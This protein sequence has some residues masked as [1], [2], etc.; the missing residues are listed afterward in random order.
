MR[1]E[2]PHLSVSMDIAGCRDYMGSLCRTV[3]DCRRQ[4][5]A[6]LCPVC[7]TN[8]CANTHTLTHT[9]REVALHGRRQGEHTHTR[10][11]THTHTQTHAR[12]HEKTPLRA[13]MRYKCSRVQRHT[14]VHVHTLS[15]THTL[16]GTHTCTHT[17][18]QTYTHA[19][20]RTH[21]HTH[22][23]THTAPRRCTLAHH[24]QNWHLTAPSSGRK[25][26]GL[27]TACFLNLFIECV[28]HLA[29]PTPNSPVLTSG[30]FA[31]LVM[32]R[33]PR[34]LRFSHRSMTPR[35]NFYVT[36]GTDWTIFSTLS[37]G[38][39]VK[40]DTLASKSLTPASKSLTP[41]CLCENPY[42]FNTLHWVS[43]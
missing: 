27:E 7:I 41:P 21:T 16:K 6:K 15:A 24:T 30:L 13:H 36:P 23:H 10:T 20:T 34:E 14:R 17:N 33:A 25:N 40:F 19:H 2:S 39:H 43:C 22:T 3:A 35:Q 9:H 26:G 4:Y 32:R 28:T 8:G 38:H 11:H 5:D 42:F 31:C 1:P 29:L 18:T 37:I 12:A